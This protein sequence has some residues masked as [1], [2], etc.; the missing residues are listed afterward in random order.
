MADAPNITRIATRLK[1]RIVETAAEHTGSHYLPDGE[2]VW[3]VG[4]GK[5]VRLDHWARERLLDIYQHS[6]AASEFNALHA[7][8]VKAGGIERCSPFRPQPAA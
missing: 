7:A 2:D 4:L 3:M 5:P 1:L 6:G 8:H